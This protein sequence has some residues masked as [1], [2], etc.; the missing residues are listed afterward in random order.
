MS[1]VALV[2]RAAVFLLACACMVGC[3]GTQQNLGYPVGQV[4]HIS[5]NAK[6][7]NVCPNGTMKVCDR[8]KPIDCQCR[9][10]R[11]IRALIGA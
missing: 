5:P 1:N 8:R 2:R 6:Q 4:N 11:H 3:A 9:S 10:A 7:N